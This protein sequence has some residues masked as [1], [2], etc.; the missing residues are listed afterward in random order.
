VS[1]V[2]LTIEEFSDGRFAASL[3]PETLERTTLHRLRPGD[4][5]NLE[6][7]LAVGDPLGG[8]HVTGH[9][10]GMVR[11]A[12]IDED[13]GTLGAAFDAPADLARFIAPRGSVALDG[14]SLTVN[15]VSDRRFR[16]TII[17]HT[18]SVT[19]LGAVCVGDLLNIEVDLVARYLARLVEARDGA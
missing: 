15:A 12:S 16:V 18:R 11:V 6:P 8:H 7:A 13:S 9:V 2:C 14:V 17:P 3:S 1:G 10:D 4:A 19:T 5:V